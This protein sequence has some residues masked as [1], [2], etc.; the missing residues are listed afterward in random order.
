MNFKII[1]YFK[2]L[3]YPKIASWL[4]RKPISEKKINLILD[5]MI[6]NNPNIPTAELQQMRNKLIM[7]PH[8]RKAIEMDIQKLFRRF[9]IDEKTGEFMKK[10]DSDIFDS[11]LKTFAK[12]YNVS[13][14]SIYDIV[15]ST[16][17]ELPKRLDKLHTMINKQLY[18]P[19]AVSGASEK[20]ISS[21]SP[22]LQRQYI[23]TLLR[24]QLKTLPTSLEK[25]ILAISSTTISGNIGSNIINKLQNGE[26]LSNEEIAIVTKATEQI[27][28]NDIESFIQSTKKA[29]EEHI[30]QDSNILTRIHKWVMEKLTNIGNSILSIITTTDEQGNK[31]IDYMKTFGLALFCATICIIL[32]K[33]VKWFVS[34]DSKEIEESVEI[35][36]KNL[37]N[38]ITTITENF[39]NKIILESEQD[40]MNKIKQAIPLIQPLN[41]YYILSQEENNDISLVR[42]IG[43][44]LFGGLAGLCST[45]LFCSIIKMNI[46]R[47]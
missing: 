15:V 6:K 7:Q 29:E 24:S 35:L 39:N 40:N 33:I 30:V 47:D 4:F 32:Y 20:I 8:T 17:D 14:G 16:K 3:T 36:D 45:M 26:L 12:K 44:F 2:N 31:N 13:Q 1:K 28:I 37:S 11:T 25:G 22:Q 9:P 41:K 38:M 10:V 43:Y 5:K 18:N 46:G 27:P 21:L 34:D 42:K 19:S 23:D